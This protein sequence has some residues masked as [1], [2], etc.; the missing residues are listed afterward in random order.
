MIKTRFI[1]WATAFFVALSIWVTTY[2]YAHNTKVL[3]SPVEVRHDA[4]NFIYNNLDNIELKLTL[5]GSEEAFQG[6]ESIPLIIKL[7]SY[8]APINGKRIPIL[9]KD[10]I[11]P[12]KLS[13]VDYTPK[14]I[15]L[16]IDIIRRKRVQVNIIDELTNPDDETQEI[17][18]VSF[19]P[20]DIAISGP[21]KIVDNIYDISTSYI[22][23]KK[24]IKNNGTVTGKLYPLY[25]RLKL[26]QD[27]VNILYDIALP[28]KTVILSKRLKLTSSKEFTLASNKILP[29]IKATVKGPKSIIEK[30]QPEEYE[31]FI[32]YKPE[33]ALLEIKFW[34]KYKS[35]NVLFISPKQ[36]SVL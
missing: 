19:L 16:D 32:D 31:F 23:Y 17:R 22:S 13:L 36:Y 29:I 35:I 5:K 11:L 28:S 20:K 1:Q 21:S 14:E 6:V 10:I 33:K 2:K 18:R 30:L 27:T 3:V 4:N 8:R 9:K 15:E 34:S 25:K 7:P 26:E 12:E 24:I